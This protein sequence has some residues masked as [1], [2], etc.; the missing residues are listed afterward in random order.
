MTR[1]PQ[2][3]ILGLA[4]GLVLGGAAAEA[5]PGAE[6]TAAELMDRV[7]AN[8]PRETLILRGQL[9]RGARIGRLERA[10]RVEARLDWGQNPPTARYTIG[11]FFGEPIARLTVSRPPG[12][13]QEFHYEAGRPLQ[14]APVPGLDQ[15][16][17][18]TELTW[19]DLSLS[20]LWWPGGALAGRDNVRGR[21][22]AVVEVPAPAADIAASNALASVRLWIDD[23]LAVPIQMEEY[24]AGNRVLRRISVKNFKKVGDLWMVKNMDV[25]RYPSRHRTQIRIEEVVA[26]DA[27][28]TPASNATEVELAGED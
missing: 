5:E 4:V 23:S 2:L 22:C 15:P 28:N 3:A 12:R 8:L 10:Y 27:T 13:P 20:F 18:G 17:E 21:A 25:L 9:M 19:H 11:D 1:R 24:D 7:R 26:G 16:I 6:P 14:P